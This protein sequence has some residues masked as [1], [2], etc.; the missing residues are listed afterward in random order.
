MELLSLQFLCFL[1]CLLAAYY[2][3]GRFAPRAQW[4]ALLVGSAVFYGVCGGWALLGLVVAMAAVTWAGSRALAALDAQGKAARKQAKGREARKAAKARFVRRRRLVLA[5]VFAVCLGVLGYFKYWN[6]IL[7]NVG[8]AASPTSLGI[9]LPLGI[10]F[11]LFASLGYVMEVYNGR[12][13]PEAS[14][15]RY[16]LFVS[17]FPQV[18]QGPINRYAEVAPQLFASRR[19]ADVDPRPALLRLGYGLL[20]KFA[21]ANVVAQNYQLILGSVS[22]DTTGPVIMLGILYY[23]IYMYADFSGG[24]DMVEGVSELFGVQMAQNFRQPYFSTSLA[25]FWRRWHMS[26][27]HW[28]KTYVFYPLAV[29]GPMRRLNR[30]ATQKLGKQTGRTI[31]ACVANVVVFLVVGLWHGAEWHYLAWGLYNGVVIALADL[32]APAF[33]RITSALHLRTESGAYRAFRIVRTFAVVCIGRYFD[34]IESV[35][36]ALLCLRNSVCNL[37]FAGFGAQLAA[38]QVDLVHEL[39]YGFPAIFAGIFVFVVSL[40]YERGVDVRAHILAMPFWRRALVICTGVA[41][42]ASAAR[43]I[44]EGGLLFVYAFF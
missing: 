12:L 15:V 43:Y 44:S 24:I 29:C 35:P 22:A 39:V 34:A 38:A 16:L 31:S 19:A 42:F 21:I 8:L 20:K 9:V 36:T 6:A 2:A 4:V 17:W 33:A 41:I 7:F 32:L 3:L 18:I 1:G 11:Y 37:T 30:A 25:D 5:G 10:S 28:M 23:S 13:E 26:L 27:G 14:F 40:A